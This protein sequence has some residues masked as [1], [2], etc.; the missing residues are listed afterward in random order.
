M[1][2]RS[3]L[4][5]QTL[6]IT[7]RTTQRTM[8]LRP[9]PPTN[10]TVL[11]ALALAAKRTGV[12]VIL[13]C[14]EAN[15]HHT[16]AYDRHGRAPEFT[17]YF[18]GLTARAMNSLRG[19]VENF[20]ASEQTNVVRLLDL[21]AI[22]DK[23]VYAATNPVKDGLVARVRHW[24]GVNGLRALLKRRTI[25]VKRPRHFFRDDGDLPEEIELE[26]GLPP[27]LG[28]PEPI[29]AEIERRVAAFEARM[30]AERDRKSV[31]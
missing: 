19:R 13:P 22:I 16:A 23:I 6:L 26:L 2:P 15:H 12:Q 27:E 21:E 3:V 24:P 1:Q 31:V 4:P 28:D 7:R 11:Y 8:L 30:D 20:W 9:D 10:E 17:H 25:I 5:G 14:V 29:L 18:H